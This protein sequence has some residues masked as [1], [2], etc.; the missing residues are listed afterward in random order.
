M[1]FVPTVNNDACKNKQN[2]QK[3]NKYLWMVALTGYL[4]DN[5]IIKLINLIIF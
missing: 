2:N 3:M 4:I 1:L 5:A